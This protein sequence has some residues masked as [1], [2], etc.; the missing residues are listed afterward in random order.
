MLLAMVRVANENAI[1]VTLAQT[2]SHHLR[3]AL[4][5]GGGVDVA[6]LDQ[7]GDVGID[8]TVTPVP[9]LLQAQAPEVA[10]AV[11]A[12]TVWG[13][14]RAAQLANF[15]RKRNGS[16]RKGQFQLMGWMICWV[17]SFPKNSKRKYSVT[18]M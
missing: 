3:P 6:S 11:P 12:W 9:A 13:D 2:L 8:I 18:N 17:R 10:S 7:S 14:L 1:V 15:L 5:T 16:G 4:P